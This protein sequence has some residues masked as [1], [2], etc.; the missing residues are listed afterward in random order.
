MSELKSELEQRVNETSR[1]SQNELKIDAFDHLGVLMTPPEETSE[2][3]KNSLVLKDGII[4][5][6]DGTKYT[7]LVKTLSTTVGEHTEEQL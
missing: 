6:W 1:K 2:L 7:D 5:V 4:Q 3:Q